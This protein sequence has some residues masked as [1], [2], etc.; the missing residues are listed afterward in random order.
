[1]M[2]GPTERGGLV[3]AHRGR[4]ARDDGRTAGSRP[5][6]RGCDPDV[7]HADLAGDCGLLRRAPEAV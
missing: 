2:P 1:M 6:W 4:A 7:M 3:I 5:G